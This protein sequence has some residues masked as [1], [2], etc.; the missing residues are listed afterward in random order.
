MIHVGAARV[1]MRG[2]CRGSFNNFMTSLDEAEKQQEHLLSN[3]IRDLSATAYGRLFRL[4]PS[5]GYAEYARKIPI[6]SYDEL[7]PYIERC[8]SGEQGLLTCRKI[9]FFERTSGGLQTAKNIPYTKALQNSFARM[10]RIW[11]YDVLNHLYRPRTGRIFMLVSPVPRNKSRERPSRSPGLP[12]DSQ[13]LSRLVRWTLRPF[14]VTLSH[15]DGAS[16]VKAIQAAIVKRHDL[17]V[18]SIWSPSL[19]CVILEQLAVK[20]PQ[21][22]RARWPSLKLISCWTCGPSSVFANRISKLFPHVRIQGKGLLATEAPITIP[23]CSAEGYV[24]LVDEVFLEFEDGDGRILRLHELEDCKAYS[25]LISQK[26]GLHRY[27]LGD[28][29]Q[30]RGFY[31]G[32]PKLHFLGRS[33]RVCD[34]VGEKLSEP[35]LEE[36]VGPLVDAYFCVIPYLDNGTAGYELLVGG[37]NGLS[38]ARGEQALLRNFHY[39]RARELGQLA[40]LQVISIP[41]L[42]DRVQA[43]YLSQG[44]KPGDFKP[45]RLIVDLDQCR[46]LRAFLHCEAPRRRSAHRE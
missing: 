21:E 4:E 11:A 38:A 40:P 15:S 34:L 12:D 20:T 18:I 14:L 27:Q 35:Y 30:V 32:V 10:F 42:L 37:R 26:G 3:L 36:A 31:K 5:D 46:H 1:L 13:Y 45:P 33:D 41:E 22:A 39:R 29:V 6:V 9:R 19:L 8:R 28:L 7:S 16:P 2:L 25:V 44:T 17:E 23:L 24:P 43:F